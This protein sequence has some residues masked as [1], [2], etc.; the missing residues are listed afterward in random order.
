MKKKW[1]L[2]RMNWKPLFLLLSTS[3]VIASFDLQYKASADEMT[4]GPTIDYGYL[5]FTEPTISIASYARS[6]NS[7]ALFAVA[8]T[9]DN[10][11]ADKNGL[12]VP[13]ALLVD[14]KEGSGRFNFMEKLPAKNKQEY[15]MD[16]L[17]LEIIK[18]CQLHKKLWKHLDW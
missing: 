15:T 8:I 14:C 18:F 6:E 10:Q 13:S 16:T 7:K 17:R 2:L 12:V 4:D 5:S 1:F 3:V 9:T 11:I